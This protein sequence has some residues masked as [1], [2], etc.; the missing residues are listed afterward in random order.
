[1]KICNWITA[2]ALLLNVETANA[3]IT[4]NSPTTF[5]SEF[6][7][8]TGAVIHIA[9]GSISNA[10]LQNSSITINGS[11]IPLGGSVSITSCP[12]G[13]NG[14]IL[15]WTSGNCSSDPTHLGWNVTNGNMTVIGNTGG[16]G[17]DMA[18]RFIGGVHGTHE[19]IRVGESSSIDS[20]YLAIGYSES[21]PTGIINS[22][23]MIQFNSGSVFVGCSALWG[24]D[25]GGLKVCGDNGSG[26]VLRWYNGGGQRGELYVTNDSNQASVLSMD[27]GISNNVVVNT[28]G[29]SFFIGGAVKIS[30]GYIVSALPS[31]TIGDRAYVT[32]A[33]A[34]TL[35]GTL[36][37]SGSTVCPVFFDGSSWLGG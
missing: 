24:A 34:C 30:P 6:T 10:Q 19:A 35:L 20:N 23:G 1:M 5:G 36:I 32:D 16:L 29:E 4:V 26:H 12:G 17:Q 14:G 8:S 9:N 13:S 25:Q 11:A 31:G 33:V 28:L 2:A 15:F 21:G 18:A 3:N 7:T 22:T 37:G 27:A